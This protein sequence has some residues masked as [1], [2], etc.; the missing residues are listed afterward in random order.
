MYFLLNPLPFLA[1]TPKQAKLMENSHGWLGASTSAS[2]AGKSGKYDK[3][4]RKTF[5]WY[6][7]LVLG[8]FRVQHESGVAWCRLDAKRQKTARS[9]VWCSGVIFMWQSHKWACW[10]LLWLMYSVCFTNQ[11]ADI[12]YSMLYKRVYLKFI[13][14]VYNSLTILSLR[15]TATHTNTKRTFNDRYA[16]KERRKKHAFI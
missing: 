10:I 1:S 6:I 12:G 7:I 14:N 9:R 16:W 8:G 13:P 3:P 15:I 5:H 11:L 4:N 2:I